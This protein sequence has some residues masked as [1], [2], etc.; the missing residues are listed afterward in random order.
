MESPSFIVC[1]E[2]KLTDQEEKIFDTLKEVLRING[3]NT[4]LRVAGGWVRDKLIGRESHDIDIALDD[5][6]GKE[7]AE[8]INNHLYPGQ[9]KFGVIKKDA[10]NSKHLETAAIK[11]HDCFVDLV[12]L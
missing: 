5:M 8:M 3:K 7:F 11:V 6:M 10:E 2:I 4:V 9:T 1:E 12:N